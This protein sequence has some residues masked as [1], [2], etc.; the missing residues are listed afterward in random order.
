MTAKPS[1]KNRAPL[2]L[3]MGWVGLLATIVV[4]AS[5]AL[6]WPM[7]VRALS[8]MVLLGSMIVMLLTRR[9]DEY[10]FELWSGAATAAFLVFVVLTLFQPFFT[11]VYDGI[12]AS[13][14]RTLEI[15]DD[16]A[17]FV[18]LLAFY[19]TF[20]VKRLRGVS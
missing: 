2:N 3:A 7:A 14:E 20:N 11:G 15:S 18:T 16:L 17:Q 1:R 9:S 10:T 4:I 5:H 6:E 12:L 13:S 8:M 19:L